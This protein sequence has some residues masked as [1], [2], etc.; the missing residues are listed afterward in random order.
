MIRL[1]IMILI[2]FL[3]CEDNSTQSVITGC[4]SSVACNYDPDATENDDTCISPEGCNE[5]C[6]GD[7]TEVQAVLMYVG[8]MV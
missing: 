7:S 3:S 8:G 2:L 6:E 4:T 5:W 1:V